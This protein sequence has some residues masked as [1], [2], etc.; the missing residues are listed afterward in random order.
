LKDIN[1]KMGIVITT[2][3]QGMSIVNCYS[4]ALLGSYL[5]TMFLTLYK[6]LIEQGGVARTLLTW[7]YTTHIIYEKVS[8]K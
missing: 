4:I 6:K 7:S 2:N 5:H 3:T 1:S 8:L